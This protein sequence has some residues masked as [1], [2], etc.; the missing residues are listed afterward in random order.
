L[1]GELPHREVAEV[2]EQ[3]MADVGAA[4]RVSTPPKE[5]DFAAAGAWSEKRTDRRS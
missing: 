4:G 3:G 2:I 5:T 1:K